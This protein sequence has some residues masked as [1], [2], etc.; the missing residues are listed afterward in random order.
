MV[1]GSIA[2]H[3]PKP[4]VPLSPLVLLQG[5]TRK[6]RSGSVTARLGMPTPGKALRVLENQ[7]KQAV[8]I[9]LLSPW[10]WDSPAAVFGCEEGQ[11]PHS[12]P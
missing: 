11:C 6:A 12:C 4:T 7:D 9:L 5:G 1:Q 3:C 2:E 8:S 10:V